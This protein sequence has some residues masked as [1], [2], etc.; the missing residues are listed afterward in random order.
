MPVTR[1]EVTQ[2]RPLAGGRAFGDA[3]RYEELLGRIHLAID[4]QHASNR[5][6]T[7]VELAPRNAAGRVACAAD[8]SILLPVD[9]ERASG[10]RVR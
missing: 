5:A 10:R 6:I 2:R 7:D 4:P 9:R 8:V 1:F 3:G